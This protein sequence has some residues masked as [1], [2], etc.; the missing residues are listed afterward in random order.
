MRA[1]LAALMLVGVAVTISGCARFAFFQ[2]EDLTGPETGIKF[3]S[4]KPYLLVAHTGASDHPI[5]V[6]VVYIPDLSKPQY[7]VPQV[8]I[9]SNNLT[10]TLTASGTFNTFGQVTDSQIP[11]LITALGGLAT[12]LATAR[13]TNREASPQPQTAPDYAAASDALGTIAADLQTQLAQASQ[14]N[15]LTTLEVQAGNSI[16]NTLRGA[17]D[18]LRDPRQAAQRA[19][20]VAV[21]LKNALDI[22]N[23]QIRAPSTVNAGREPQIRRQLAVLYEQVQDVLAQILP[24]EEDEFTFALYEIDNSKPP[25]TVLK[26]VNFKP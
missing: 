3:Y 8:G 14:A 25:G 1:V 24:T 21:N 9:G 15:A 5:D 13:K 23:N 16:F 17:S 18:L 2:R 4:P 20:A 7:A 11:Q 22:W 12:S 26:K 6:S 10:L 19:P